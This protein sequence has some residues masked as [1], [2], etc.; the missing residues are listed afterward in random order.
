MLSSTF[1]TESTFIAKDIKKI[2]CVPRRVGQFSNL[3][4]K[5]G[6]ICISSVIPEL[7]KKFPAIAL[8]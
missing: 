1:I 6:V 8:V 3:A 2:Y 4:S 5:L 7:N